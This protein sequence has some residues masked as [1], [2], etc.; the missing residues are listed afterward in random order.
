MHSISYS[1]NIL[2]FF[3]AQGLLFF[4]KVHPLLYLEYLHHSQGYNL[5][6]IATC[7]CDQLRMQLS[8]C[9]EA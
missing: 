8:L 1:S 3:T 6:Q 5:R 4:P 9:N 7:A 2:P